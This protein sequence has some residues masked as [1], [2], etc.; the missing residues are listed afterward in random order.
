LKKIAL[1]A[2]GIAA[3][4]SAS[5][6]TFEAKAAELRADYLAELAELQLEAA[7]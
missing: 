6:K 7:E 1:A 3:S 2:P 5:P 4:M